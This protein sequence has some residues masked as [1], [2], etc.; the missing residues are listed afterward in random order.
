MIG[1]CGNDSSQF[2]LGTSSKSLSRMLDRTGGR[3]WGQGVY[4]VERSTYW[5]RH[6]QCRSSI[7]DPH[8]QPNFLFQ[9]RKRR[10]SNFSYGWICFPRWEIWKILPLHRKCIRRLIVPMREIMASFINFS[11]HMRFSLN[12]INEFFKI[13]IDLNKISMSPEISAEKVSREDLWQMWCWWL[14]HRISRK[15]LELVTNTNCLESS[16]M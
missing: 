1:E 9:N 7:S 16:L 8:H 15:C 4:G 14:Y 2:S 5:T 3:V 11:R 10:Q 13:I 12:H 6:S